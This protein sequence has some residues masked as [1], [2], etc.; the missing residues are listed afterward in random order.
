[1]LTDYH[2]TI[3]QLK[4]KEKTADEKIR[5]LEE[6]LSKMQQNQKSKT[7]D[8]VSLTYSSEIL[9]TETK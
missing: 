3:E 7:T 4:S 9:N 1:M 8:S 6:Q 2:H 5:E